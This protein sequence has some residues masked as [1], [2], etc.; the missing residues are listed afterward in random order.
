LRRPQR[1]LA[2]RGGDAW[3]SFTTDWTLTGLKMNPNATMH[4]EREQYVL[5]PLMISIV[6]DMNRKT[7][8]MRIKT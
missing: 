3:C 5:M 1:V 7:E 4:E 2:V 8:K 6:Q